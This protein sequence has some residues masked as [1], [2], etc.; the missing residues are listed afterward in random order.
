M[1]TA[2]SGLDK[3]ADNIAKLSQRR[4]TGTLILSSEAQYEGQLHLFYGR[5][6][7]AIGRSHRVRCWDRTLKQSC[8]NWKVTLDSEPEEEPWEY[9]LLHLGVARERLSV[10]EAKAAIRNSARE[11]FFSLA[12]SPNLTCRWDCRAEASSTMTLTL[13]LSAVEV[14][15]VI[16]EARELW[17]QWLTLGFGKISPNLAPTL[18]EDAAEYFPRLQQVLTGEKTLWDLAVSLQQPIEGVARA[19]L[20]FAK[21]G[22]VKFEHIPD[23]PTPFALVSQTKADVIKIQPPPQQIIACIDDSPTVGQFVEQVLTPFGYR[24]LK[25]QDP[26]RATTLLAKHKPSLIFLDLVM[27]NADGYSLCTFLRQSPAFRETPII[28]L[29]S[30][31]S[32]IDRTRAKLAKASDF[33]TKPPEPEKLLQMVEKHLKICLV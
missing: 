2:V 4:A 33:L 14:E 29:T 13:P 20:P 17:Q 30:R 6:L 10:S 12:L 26:L 7:Y 19:L 1:A 25:I 3:L 9:Q 16:Q 24:V 8:P 5:L 11:V 18:K 31:N 23:V 21:K 28:I 15:Q 27:P 22:V 32:I